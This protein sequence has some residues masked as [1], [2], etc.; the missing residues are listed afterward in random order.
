MILENSHPGAP[1]YVNIEHTTFA[2]NTDAAGRASAVLCV[3][4]DAIVRPSYTVFSDE[5]GR[6]LDVA[7]N[8]AFD[9]QGA[10]FSDDSTQTS[11]TQ[12]G[13]PGLVVLLDHVTDRVSTDAWLSPLASSGDPTPYYELLAGSPAINYAIGSSSAADQRGVLRT[14]VPD[15]G[16]FEYNASGRLVINE[17]YAGTGAVHYIELFVRRD[18]APVDLANYSLFVGDTAVHSFR[19]NLS[20]GTNDLFSAGATNSSIIRPGFGMVVAFTTNPVF[21]TANGN[22][23]PVV[24]PSLLPTSRLPAQSVISVGLN[25]G[26]P[27]TRQSYLTRY[28]DPSSGTNLLDVANESIALAPQFRGHALIPHS[29]VKSGPFEGGDASQALGTDPH[30]PAAD[31]DDVPFGLANAFPVALSDHLHGHRG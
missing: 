10:N 29:F 13:A 27:F 26:A 6:N 31:A 28:L 11:F 23:N 19:T 8:G 21:L 22:P 3:N 2:E 14:G 1:M 20:I 18:S 5:S 12:G 4:E 16:S 17:I 15:S 9:S 30:S 7:G 25:F 24:R